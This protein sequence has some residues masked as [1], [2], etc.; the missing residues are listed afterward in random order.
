MDQRLKILPK[1]LNKHLHPQLS[2]AL[3][4]R[5]SQKR[6]RVLSLCFRLA[7]CVCVCVCRYVFGHFAFYCFMVFA[8]MLLGF[9]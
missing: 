9:G 5:K 4:N 2:S 3:K 6:P 7:V 1:T 8:K